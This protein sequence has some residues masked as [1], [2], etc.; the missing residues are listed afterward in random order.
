[1]KLI[2]V[3][4]RLKSDETHSLEFHIA[5]TETI[6]RGIVRNFKGEYLPVAPHLYLPHF[7]NDNNVDERQMA[8]SIGIELLKKCCEMKV[9]VVDGIISEG[10]LAEIYAAQ[11]E[12]IPIDFFYCTKEE[13]MEIIT[14][15][16]E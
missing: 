16:K 13:M 6:C 10:M 4:S 2:Y 9:I 8:C 14:F 7:M 12:G 11:Q 3:C 15:N 5:V 1:M